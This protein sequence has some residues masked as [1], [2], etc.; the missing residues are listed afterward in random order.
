VSS[1]ILVGLMAYYRVV[2]TASILALAPLI[3][4]TTLLALACGML[5]SSLNVKYRDVGVAMPV[6]MQLWMYLS[7]VLYPLSLVPEGWRQVYALN[8]MVGFVSGFRAAVLGGEFD[9]YALAV[10]ASFTLA[11]LV[12]ASY[13]FRRVEREFAD[14]I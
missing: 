1:L 2:P 13:L 12:C 7:P 9:W 11:L 5:T 4:M 8:P 10:S 14:V 6:L 3:A